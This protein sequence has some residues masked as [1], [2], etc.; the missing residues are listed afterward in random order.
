MDRNLDAARSGPLW[1]TREEIARDAAEFARIVRYIENNP[2]RAG[3]ASKPEEYRWS[4]AY[5]RAL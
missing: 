5:G 1:L 2:V 3:L 4:S